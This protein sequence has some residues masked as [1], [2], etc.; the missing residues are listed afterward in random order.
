MTDGFGPD[1][2]DAVPVKAA[3]AAAAL[4]A[5]LLEVPVAAPARSFSLPRPAWAG[6]DRV[7]AAMA[8]TRAVLRIM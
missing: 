4:E 3:E 7:A 1:G 2:I 5:L 6:I 8:R